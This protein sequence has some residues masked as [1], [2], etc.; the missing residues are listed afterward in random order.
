MTDALSDASLN[1]DSN[2]PDEPE[3]EPDDEQLVEPE[4]VEVENDPVTARNPDPAAGSEHERNQ[5][6]T[7]TYNV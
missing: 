3:F 6:L 7:E 4:P 5:R 1:D 2:Q